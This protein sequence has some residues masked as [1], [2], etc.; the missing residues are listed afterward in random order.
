MLEAIGKIITNVLTALYQNFWFS[1]LSAILFM[2]LY[3]SVQERG[4]KGS[5]KIW[6]DR[7]KKSGSFRRIFVLV[8]FII[9]TLMRTVLVKLFCNT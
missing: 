6:I 1:V 2:F 3:L 4:W 7:F 5:I 9:M 8:V